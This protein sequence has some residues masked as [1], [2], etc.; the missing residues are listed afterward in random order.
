MTGQR[1]YYEWE[2]HVSDEWTIDLQFVTGA[3]WGNAGYCC[4]AIIGRAD[5]EV[6]QIPRIRVHAWSD[7]PDEAQY[8]AFKRA[9]YYLEFGKLPPPALVGMLDEA[10][11][12][13]IELGGGMQLVPE[14]VP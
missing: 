7:S 13:V 14:L 6:D 12:A 1:H 5:G 8:H 4:A 10:S 3:N 11:G 2:P 9:A